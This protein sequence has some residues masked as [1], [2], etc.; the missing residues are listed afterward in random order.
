MIAPSQRLLTT[1]T[2][3][4]HAPGG[5]RTRNPSKR[6]TVDPRASDRAATG[7][8][9]LTLLSRNTKIHEICYREAASG[10]DDKRTAYTSTKMDVTV[11]EN[12]IMTAYKEMQYS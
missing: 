3:D 12:K 2:T 5:I 4:I 6:A 8:G 11:M 1:L 7:T 9:V 10:K